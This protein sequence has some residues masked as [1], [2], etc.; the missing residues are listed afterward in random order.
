MSNQTLGV[1]F[2]CDVKTVQVEVIAKRIKTTILT[3]KKVKKKIEK[4]HITHH[5]NKSTKKV[6][7]ICHLSIGHVK[8]KTRMTELLREKQALQTVRCAYLQRR[9]ERRH[10]VQTE[11]PRRAPRP[12]HTLRPGL[13]VVSVV[14]LPPGADAGAEQENNPQGQARRGGATC[15]QHLVRGARG[16]CETRGCAGD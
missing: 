13:I 14:V 10:T 5:E 11:A 7:L 4:N 15:G 2:G 3:S 8:P 6:H 12:G 9:G 1:T 16:G